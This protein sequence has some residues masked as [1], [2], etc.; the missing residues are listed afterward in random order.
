MDRYGHNL[1]DTPGLEE[2]ERL[3]QL[4]DQRRFDEVLVRGQVLLEQPETGSFTRAKTHNMLCWVFI[5]GIKRPTPEAVLHGE[6][7][8]RLAERLEEQGLRVQSLCNL[9]SACYQIG[10]FDQA[11]QCYFQ[12]MRLLTERPSLL[13]YGKVLAL[14]GLAQIDMVRGEHAEAVKKLNEAEQL[15]T[16]DESRCLLADV[17]RRQAMA[18]LRL[19]QPHKA[20]EQL[21]KVDE[22]S[23]S[24]GLRGLW[25]RTHL[26]ITKA[27][28]EIAMGR[29]PTARTVATNTM[30]LARELGDM[31][32]LA[33]CACLLATVE[34][35]EGRKEVHKRA[36]A[37]LTFAIQ[38]GRR[39]VVDDIRE[40]MKDYLT[41]EI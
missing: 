3:L 7:A 15:C 6:E 12:V 24:N 4:L 32:V 18:L 5:E 23:L 21:A 11:E 39:D 26:G 13:P 17:Y 22:A 36:R 29:W 38:S 10:D 19:D 9:A 31:P 14:Q 16:D 27:R 33:E 35:A 1:P 37:A 34:A 20:A 40:R 8:V 28:V 25:W 2:Y 41:T 30:A